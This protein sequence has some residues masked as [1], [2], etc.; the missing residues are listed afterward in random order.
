MFRR[1]VL[2]PLAGR[3]GTSL[4]MKFGRERYSQTSWNSKSF[5]PKRNDFAAKPASTR[6]ECCHIPDTSA[7]GEIE[8]FGEFADAQIDLVFVCASITEDQAAARRA[9]QAASRKRDN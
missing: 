8:D 4:H 1:A 6:Q 9:I 3:T 7:L 2:L 5:S